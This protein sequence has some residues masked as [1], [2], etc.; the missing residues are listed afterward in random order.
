MSW[1]VGGWKQKKELPCDSKVNHKFVTR[2]ICHVF[3]TI[4]NTLLN[5]TEAHGAQKLKNHLLN[6]IK[7]LN[8]PALAFF[9]SAKQKGA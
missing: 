5:K 2:R 8:R 1:L 7:A 4:L 3:H 6:A 9:S